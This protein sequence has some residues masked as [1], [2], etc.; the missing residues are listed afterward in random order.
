MLWYM[1][2]TACD[3]TLG[4]MYESHLLRNIACTAKVESHNRL[5]EFAGG[6]PKPQ[7]SSPV[8][9]STHLCLLATCRWELFTREWAHQSV[10]SS[11]GVGALDVSER[12]AT[13]TLLCAQVKP[14]YCSPQLGPVFSQL[15]PVTELISD[16]WKTHLHLLVYFR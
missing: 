13:V 1:L 12:N 8:I 4:V 7:G 11:G 6:A 2:H 5:L 16:F 14:R 9:V 3:L 10:A 15:R